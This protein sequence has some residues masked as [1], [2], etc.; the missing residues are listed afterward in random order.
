MG[1]EMKDQGWTVGFLEGD[2]AD[3]PRWRSLVEAL[4]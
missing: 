1:R 4:L 2:A 3:R